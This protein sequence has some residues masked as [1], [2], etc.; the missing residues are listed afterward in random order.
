MVHVLR[1]RRSVVTDSF[2]TRLDAHPLAYHEPSLLR[3]HSGPRDTPR[4]RNTPSEG[5]HSSGEAF[6][7]SLAVTQ[8]APTNHQTTGSGHSTPGRVILEGL[9]HRCPPPVA[10]NCPA[11]QGRRDSEYFPPAQPV[12]ARHPQPSRHAKIMPSPARNGPPPAGWLGSDPV[13]LASTHQGCVPRANT[14]HPA[15]HGSS[16]RSANTCEQR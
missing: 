5:Q 10:S 8:S 14:P 9:H 7:S 12:G 2:V 4:L 3:S 16:P 13:L 1:D 6:P 15:L 11:D